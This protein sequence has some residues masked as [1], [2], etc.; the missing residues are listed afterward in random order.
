M[1]SMSKI[2]ARPE[3]TGFTLIELLITVAIIGIISAIAVVNL[4]NAVDKAKQKRSMADMRTIG[5]AVE[6]YGTDNARYPAGIFTW[7]AM[8]P[9]LHPH[10]MKDPPDVDGWNNGWQVDSATGTDYSIVS[11]GKDG[12]DG[13][14]TG[15]P[16]QQFDCDI[17]FADGRFFQWPQGTQT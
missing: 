16:T 3:E 4:L 13:P 2:H 14:R 15:G 8:Q 17:V 9:I 12:T 1:T 10:F 6:A 7:A 5:Q 11:P